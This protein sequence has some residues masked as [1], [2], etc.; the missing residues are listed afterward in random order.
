MPTRAFFQS[1]AR[2]RACFLTFNSFASAQS[3]LWLV[4]EEYLDLSSFGNIIGLHEE[5][6]DSETCTVC[7]TAS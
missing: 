4:S 5:N 3:V 6:S 1:L 7:G 2:L